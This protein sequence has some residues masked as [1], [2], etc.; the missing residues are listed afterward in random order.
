[1]LNYKFSTLGVYKNTHPPISMSTKPAALRTD[2]KN[3]QFR[4]VTHKEM[5]EAI[6][7]LPINKHLGPSKIPVW[8]L[9]DSVHIINPFLTTIINECISKAE[10]PQGLKKSACYSRVQRRRYSRSNQLQA[11]FHN[12]HQLSLK[13]LKKNFQ[14]N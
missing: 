14:I 1:M 12:T 11:N 8:V 7:L 3:F 6:L 10:F 9:K 5:F 4:Y 2:T 13:Y